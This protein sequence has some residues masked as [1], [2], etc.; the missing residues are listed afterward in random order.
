MT[1]DRALTDVEMMQVTHYLRAEVLGRD[2][3]SAG[4]PEMYFP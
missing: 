2:D 4:A 3:A 1:W